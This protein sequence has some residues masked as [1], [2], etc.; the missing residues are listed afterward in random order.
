MRK[1]DNRKY[2]MGAIIVILALVML[3]KLFMIQMVDTR[4]KI[5][6][7][8]NSQRHVTEYPARGL[9][10]DRHGTL[11]VYNQAAYDL[12][13]IP[14]EMKA[15]DTLE[16]ANVVGIS[17]DEMKDGIQKAKRYSRY[18]PSVL[19]KQLN[20]ETYAILQEKLYKYPGFFVQ[21]RTLRKYPSPIAANVLGYVGEVDDKW[22]ENN[23]YYQQGDYAGISGLEKVYEE[24]LRGKKGVSIYLVNVHNTIQGSFMNGQYDT[25][26]IAGRN[27]TTTLDLELQAYG[28]RLMQNKIGSI[29]A[30]E[31]E[32]GEILALVSSPTYDP[33]LLVGRVRGQNYRSLQ[34]D[35]NKPLYNRALMAQYP[36][37]STF[38][39]ITGLVGLQEGVLNPG[40]TYACSGPNSL[41]IKCSHFHDTPIGLIHSIE[42][43]CNPYFW[44]VFQSVMDNQAYPRIQESF[45]AWRKHVMSFGL[46]QKFQTDLFS[47]S[48]GNIPDIDYFNRYYGEKGWRALTVRS[49]SIGQG[50]ILLTP[51]QLA[52]QA[53]TIANRGYFRPP[54]LVKQIEGLDSLEF[55]K[56]IHETTIHPEHFEPIIEG[57]RLV[58]AGDHGTA[59][60]YRNDSI[61]MAGKTGT[62]ENPHGDDH[63]IFIAFAPIENPRIA[64]SVVVE[65]SGF[66]STWAVPIATLMMEK[67]LKGAISRTWVETRMLEGNLMPKPESAEA[68][69]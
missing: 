12:M 53:A 30:I 37:G 46:N 8:N 67:Y 24:M 35:L 52:N 65:N 56:E 32:T 31:P 63:S 13:L 69:E 34:A 44:K 49:L 23:A 22:L 16:L 41:P 68:V 14:R 45:T 28:E 33:N 60:W 51:L 39:L 47:E 58:Y 29:V 61:P 55:Q 15:F 62:A 9:I 3:I 36:P 19:V 25:A 50:E 10:Y 5:S 20:T 42:E 1:F 59:R 21:T 26:A 2:V 27:L 54:H 40:I 4:Y 48:R 6:A 18:K 7:Q 11:M 43:S 57:M 64:I 66:G 17:V 38:K